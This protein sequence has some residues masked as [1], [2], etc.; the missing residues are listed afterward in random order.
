MKW[1]SRK[2][3][4]EGRSGR[5]AAA[6]GKLG[7]VLLAGAVGL[8]GLAWAGLGSKGA[9]RVP[10]TGNAG[11]LPGQAV[12]L[13][14]QIEETASEASV[15]TAPASTAPPPQP[16]A[17]PLIIFARRSA[18]GSH[19]WAQLAGQ[20]AQYQLTT[21]EHDDRDPV[22]S[23]DGTQLAFA[24]NRDGG[25]DLYLMELASGDVRRLTETS[26]YEG[27][28]T[29]SPDGLWLAYEAYYGDDMDIWVL[30]VDGSQ[31]AIQLT[32]DPA[33]DLEPSWDPNGRRIAFISDRDG[34]PDLFLA[35]LDKPTDRFSNLSQSPQLVERDPAFDPTGNWIAYSAR[36]DG[37]EQ[38][39]LAPA[40]LGNPA[41]W[42][43][44]GGRPSWAAGGAVL[45][46]VLSGPTRAQVVTYGLGPDS[47]AV[48]ISVAGWL[49]GMHWSATATLPGWSQPGDLGQGGAPGGTAAPE[50]R[51]GLVGLA[52]VLPEGAS[53]SSA[54]SE[55][56]MA[57]RERAARELGWDFLGQLDLAFVDLNDPL[58]P[59]FSYNDWLH[60]GRA[61]A[62][63]Q[64]AHQAGWVEVVR[65]DYGAQ[66]YWEIHVRTAQQDG[67][68]GEPLRTHPWDFGARYAGDPSIY[69]QGGAPK[70]TIPSGY[71]VD[72]TALAAGAGFERLPAL[73]NWRTYYPAARFTE[74]ALRDGLDWEQAMLQ[75]YPPEAIATPTP[76]Q[77]PTQ[78]PTNTPRPT[79]TPW[80]LRWR[81]P[82]LSPTPSP[83]ATPSAIPSPNITPVP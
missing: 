60:T 68:L 66:T 73:T 62:F 17:T 35:D 71:Y 57:L 34:S 81:T 27:R 83:T 82:T 43:G 72:F 41:E 70:P 42:I 46:A 67:M 25:W 26:G 65:E 56:F 3:V 8:G 32:S 24:S 48:G 31:P 52:G 63:S 20:T 59:G 33:S 9:P 30:A 4:R 16:G 37:L 39:W 75:L 21:G 22:I 47:T 55:P 74:F 61:F 79:P 51:L 13:P 7:L 36:W 45:A 49:E 5:F 10:E 69:D 12:G 76:F 58:P 6:P 38:I 44:Q 18:G 15:L 78:T 1:R 64:S 77:T 80:W 14:Q 2:A 53:L 40:D 29:W 50:G 11:E 28:P 54:A 19:L 23:P